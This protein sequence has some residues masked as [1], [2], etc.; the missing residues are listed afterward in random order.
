VSVINDY[1]S[2]RTGHS[3]NANQSKTTAFTNGINNKKLRIGAY[4]TFLNIYQK[5][6]N[7]RIP[8]NTKTNRCVG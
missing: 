7:G 8:R 6:I 4:P 1:F 3:A 5:Q 2:F